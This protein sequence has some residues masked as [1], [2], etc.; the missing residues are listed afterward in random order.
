M[1]AE[2][3]ARPG[4][5][6]IQEFRTVTPSVITPTLPP[7][8][9]GVCRQVVEVLESDGAGGTQLNPDSLIQMPAFFIATAASG[10][11]KR[12]TGLDGLSL[13]F[14]PN[15]GADVTVIFSDP[16]A[17]GLTPATVV[18]QVNKALLAQ[19][20]T[21]V[22]AELVGTDAWQL[23][24]VGEGEFQSI[25]IA[26]T[27]SPAVASTFG[28]GIGKTF[29]G[30]TSYN[31]YELRVP[32][33]SLP[34]PRS[35][36]AELAIEKD[37]IRAFLFTG[38]GSN[39]QEAKRTEAFLQRGE[40][41]IPAVT[42]EGTVNLDTSFPTFTNHV[43][44][45]SVDE[46]E[47]QVV[48][49]PDTVTDIAGLL[50]LLNGI[51][52]ITGVTASAVA[53]NYGLVFTHQSGGE[54]HSI[55]I[56]LPDTLSANALLGL[57]RETVVGTSIAAID[58]GNGDA[59]TPLLQFSGLNFD[60]AAS[61][62]VLTA[63]G[64]P[65]L[66]PPANSTLV[67]SDGQQP[68]TIT[69][70]GNEA[71]IADVKT[72]V[73]AIVGSAASGRITVT[74]VAGIIQLSNS[75]LGDGSSLEVIGGTALQYLD[76]GSNP[77]VT[78]EGTVDATTFPALS[79]GA[80]FDL[81]YVSGPGATP[82][83][84][85]VTASGGETTFAALRALIE[86]AVGGVTA[87]QGSNGG[88]VITGAGTGT[89]STLLIEEHGGGGAL[90]GLPVDDTFAGNGEVLVAGA[91]VR[92]TPFRPEPGDEL[93]I[94][95][96]FYA[97]VTKRSPGGLTS[98]L[99]IDRQV[100]I[101]ANIGRYFYLVA[102]NLVAGSALNG[103]SRPYP[104]LQVDVEGNVLLQSG[105]LR[106][107]RGVPVPGKAPLYLSY[108][109][110]RQ[111]VTAL[112]SQPGLLSFDSTTALSN[113]LAPINTDNPLG[114][115]L[116]FA[117]INA[118]GI[119]VTGLGVDEV[120]ADSP[121]GT[122]EAFTRAAEYLEGYEVYAI[123][124]MTHDKSV[125]EV[126]NTH[127][128]FMSQPESKGERIVLWNPEMPTHALDTLVAS[129]T[130]GDG[131]TT[132][133]FDTKVVNLSALLSNAGVN[134]IGTIPVTA[135][136]FL[137]IAGDSK[138]YSV[139]S[140]SGGV[141]TLRLVFQA[142]TNEDGYYSTT[143]L[144]LPIISTAFAIRVR[145]A[146]LLTPTGQQDKNA[147]ASTV[148]GLGQSF[149]NRRF[150][151]TFP[152]KTAATIE[153]LEQLIEGYYLNA[154]IAGMIGQQP[155]QQ[156]FTNFPMTGYTRVVGSN[157]VFNERQLN[158]M[159]A[160]GAY[161]IVQDTAG[162]PL[163]ARMALTTNMTSIETRTD[164]ITKVVDFTAKFLRRGLR[165]FI[166]RFN[167]TQGFLDT[168]GSVVQGLGGFLVE[169][170][171]LI[172]LTLNSIIQDE[173]ARDTVLIDCTLDPPYPCNYLRITLVV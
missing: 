18:D 16:T 153:G 47:V 98:V 124:P 86:A 12:Y 157:N 102:K 75:W 122:V 146:A 24:T 52:G 89:G 158:R 77:A 46:G 87:S 101:N 72:A 64:N 68:Q 26:D 97:T 90:F 30:L 161:I 133:T 96:V 50:T 149:A 14:S 159:A 151:M 34:D 115:G 104:N 94:D 128:T 169:T 150:W 129:G 140:L 127:V 76:T 32:P 35:N 111:D 137:D 56:L 62:A 88:V 163:T 135:G 83:T 126:F 8:I 99:R 136:V 15:D 19:L 166:G 29:R 100:P 1:A 95:G 117:L 80:L 43:L 49:I 138:R 33:M 51:S 61:A 81:T 107:I 155:P 66:P 84:G 10:T 48:A 160:G 37:T 36:L 91:S 92:G 121:D 130:D 78:T 168:L 116:Y 148:S 154:G 114:L 112:A 28:I 4:V 3:L 162:G 9:V 145:G 55:E 144:T 6:V 142:G 109:A 74:E 170:G 2:E 85:T 57:T 7:S 118:P 25:L 167:I 171:V 134:P 82:V 31:Q 54:D 44:W 23:R 13:A 79:A 164:S 172:G 156:S 132:V 165:N 22:V 106:D 125:A 58:D 131:L 45:L 71:T 93:W 5:E 141:V 27:T 59:V 21:S 39:L 41:A 147:V 65:A 143:G 63:A 73:E 69:F 70:D 152:D 103:V 119:Q 105:Q 113:E 42:T 60:A 40:V 20:V 108:N 173:N 11:P 139:E 53:P 120:S 110:V 123:A 67:V 17:F 38:S